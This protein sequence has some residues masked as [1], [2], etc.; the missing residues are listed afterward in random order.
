MNKSNPKKS[1]IPY[2]IL[3][4]VIIIPLLYSYFYLGA[5]WDP[6]AKLDQVPVAVV[7][8]D[9]GATINDIDRNL[10]QEMCDTLKED[11]SLKFSFTDA[12]TANDGLKAND[13]Y[14]VII[15]PSNFSEDIASSSTAS[16]QT[17]TITYSSNEK[18]NYLASQILNTA[19]EKIEKS[20]RSSVDDEIVSTLSAQLTDVPEQLQTLSDGLSTLQDG[21]TKL[22]DGTMK[23]ADASKDLH[24]GTDTLANAT[25]TLKEGTS[26]LVTGST[27]LQNGVQEIITGGKTLN[28]GLGSLSTNMKAFHSGIKSASAGS[29]SLATNMA[30]LNK[31]ID[32]LLEGATKLETGANKLT[33]LQDGAT[34]L[35]TGVSSLA[36]G[37]TS[38]TSGVDTLLDTV[39]ALTNTLNEYATATGDTTLQTIVSQLTSKENLEHMQTLRQGSTTLKQGASTLKTGAITLSTSTQNLTD[40]KAGITQIKQGLTTARQ[41]SA[42]LTTGASD[43]QKGLDTLEKSSKKLVTGTDSLYEGSNTLSK[44]L[45]TLSAGITSLADGASK[46]DSGA[47]QINDGANTLN[48]GTATLQSSTS[49]LNDGTKQLADGIQT[50]NDK[51][52]SSIT[53]ANDK[54][55]SLDNLNEYAANPV[56]IESAA[57]APV[58]N[59][60]TAF[61]PYFMSLSLWVGGLMIFFGIYFDPDNHFNLLSRRSTR[62]VK[63]SFAY[64]GIGL[65]Q[66]LILCVVLTLALGLSINNMPLYFVSCC[67]VSMVFIAIIQLF[68]FFFSNIGKFLAIALLIIQLASCGGTFPIETLPSFFKIMYPFMPMTYSVQLFKE[69]ISGTGDSI[70]IWKNVIVL[71]GILIVSIGITIG[72]ALIRKKKSSVTATEEHAI[73]Y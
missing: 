69:A 29:T 44:G 5:F 31:G 60:G 55:A 42:A 13:Y 73:I 40:L 62:V 58:P 14:A 34:S 72:F 37:I 32:T 10:G 57:Y 41:G 36:E 59:Y 23:L 17:A 20:L 46:L 65:L 35:S 24:A 68:L 16:K 63:R 28:Q 48:D 26:S 21:A 2:I 52:S 45:S 56:T 27:S 1:F 70:L 18:K 54:M 15:I 67:L 61:A 8:E 30:T 12:K 47:S 22:S 4:G 25:T 51:V 6:Y 33:D 38:Y 11:S 39:S 66:A 19:I 7:N 43:L 71:L 3:L 49:T 53:T 9:T 64:L 50:A